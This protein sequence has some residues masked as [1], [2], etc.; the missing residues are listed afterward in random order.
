MATIVVRGR[1]IRVQAKAGTQRL[2]V[3]TLYSTYTDER[4]DELE[5][6]SIEHE[7]VC[8]GASIVWQNPTDHDEKDQKEA[9]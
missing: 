9:T 3:Y 6:E 8:C 1:R 5:A 2:A 7:Q 4:L